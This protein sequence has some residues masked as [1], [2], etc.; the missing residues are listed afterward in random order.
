MSPDLLSSA[1]TIKNHMRICN[2]KKVLDFIMNNI[3][4]STRF[5]T[6]YINKN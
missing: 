2:M 3:R 5:H 4:E 1:K 6:V